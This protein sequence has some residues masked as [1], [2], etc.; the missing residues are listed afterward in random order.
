MYGKKSGVH[1]RYFR[2]PLELFP[3]NYTP[4]KRMQYALN[5]VMMMMMAMS[6]ISLVLVVEPLQQQQQTV[7]ACFFSCEKDCYVQQQSRMAEGIDDIFVE[8]RSALL[9]GRWSG[10]FFI[11]VFFSSPSNVQMLCYKIKRSTQNVVQF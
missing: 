4:Q 9:L 7:A 8:N 10:A 1:E 5:G 6:L 2:S 3:K 11:F